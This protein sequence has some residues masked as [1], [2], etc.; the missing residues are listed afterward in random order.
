MFLEAGSEDEKW[1]K[2]THLANNTFG[3]QVR[4]EA[5][6]YGGQQTTA[7]GNSACYIAGDDVRVVVVPIREGRIADWKGGIKDW[8]LEGPNAGN[9]QSNG[10]GRSGGEH[11]VNGIVG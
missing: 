2:E 7:E 5:G 8:V 1:C 10:R 6:F 4:M 11:L 3:D 9:G